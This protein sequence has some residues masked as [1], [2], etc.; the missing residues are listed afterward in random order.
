LYGLAG[1]FQQGITAVHAAMQQHAI[2][3]VQPLRAEESFS[4]EAFLT[5][6]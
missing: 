6:A 1:A 3:P 4:V 2:D 5:P